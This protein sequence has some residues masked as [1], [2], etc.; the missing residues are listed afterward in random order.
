MDTKIAITSFGSISAL[1]TDSDSI[2]QNY[3]SNKSCISKEII[4]EKEI[5]ASK[6]DALHEEKINQLLLQN[7]KYK[8]LDRTVHLAIIASR[9]AVENADWNNNTNLGINIGSSRGAT[10]LFENYIAE[11]LQ[12][13]KSTT[14]A[15]PTTTLGNI[16]SWVAFDL[17]SQGIAISHSITCSSALHSVLNG[18]AWLNSGMAE[19]FVA[20]GSEAPLT[21]FT[22]SQMQALKIYSTEEDDFPCKALDTTKKKNTMV[23][24]EGASVFCLEKNNPNALAYISGYG[25]ANEHIS[26]STSISDEGLGFQ[27]SMKMALQNHDLETIDAI[28]LHAPGTIKGDSAELLAIEKVFGNHKPIL[29]N[30]KWK[31]GHTFGASG[32][33]SL[34]LAILMIQHGYSIEIPYLEQNI[35]N[36]KI[37]KVLVNAIGFGGNAVSIL[38]EK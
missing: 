16:A 23:L 31:I 11:F 17:Q 25:F 9:I 2:W 18:M 19:K 36:R 6:I 34:E 21:P 14:L 29:T 1:G 4:G 5:W 10:H 8:S 7:Q 35:S 13:G 20:G 27:E 32:G 22:I 24:G 3:L 30:N 37:K 38:I 12:T 26:N 28:V 15:S 33:F